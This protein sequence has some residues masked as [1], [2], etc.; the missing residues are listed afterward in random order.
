MRAISAQLQAGQ[1][2]AAHDRLETVVAANPTFAEA[3]RLLA[4]TKLA[5]GDPAAAETLLR[6]ALAV[7]PAWTPTL[8]TLGELLLAG[9]RGAEAEGVLLRALKTRSPDL[10]AAWVLA[11]Y[12]NNTGRPAQALAVA[13]PLC[14]QG[15]VDAD[16]ATQHVM[17]LAA[18]GRQA[19]AISIYSSLAGAATDNLAPVQALAIALGAAGR[20]TDAA[21]I[22]HRAL[23]RGYR[24]ATLCLTYARSLMAEGA[25][26]R[27]ETALRDCLR[28]DPRQTEAHN[29]LAQLIWLRSGDL[30]QATEP[31]DEA[32]RRFGNDDALR[33]TKAAILQGA[34]DAR[35][36]YDCLAP[37]AEHPLAPPQLLVRVGVSAL[38]FD[39]AKALSLAQRA[40]R[41]MPDSGAARSLLA[42]SLLGVGDAQAALRECEALQPQAPDDQYLI[43]LQATALRLLGDERYAQ[44]YDYRNLVLSLPIEPPPPWSD[45]ASFLADLETSLN[46]FHDPNGHA[47]L[48]QSLRHGTETTQDLTRSADAAVRGLFQSFAAPIARYLEHIGNG[49]DPLRRR[50]NGRW[51]F[52]GSWSVRLRDRGFHMSHVHPRGWISSAFYVKLPDI[53]ADDRTDEGVLSFGKPGILTSPPLEAEYTVRPTPGL[54][55][56]FPSYFWHGTIPFQSPQS[57]LTV[58]FDAVPER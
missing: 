48:F 47:L 5:L 9:G 33:A 6:Q 3:Q 56:L 12:Y 8:T 18:L 24:T 20:H 36:A 57:R 30:T 39:A 46:R 43:A 1:F 40:L 7:D 42:A 31:L 23:A 41:A 55:V 11:C 10:R 16:L 35:A 13:G 28:L 53:M 29:S 45:L 14:T 27:A 51:R 32:L 22:A 52:N 26:E 17:A 25:N 50:N 58:A 54:L 34:G 19:E 44:L 21:Q 4:G 49:T 2:R 38:D 15:R 37:L